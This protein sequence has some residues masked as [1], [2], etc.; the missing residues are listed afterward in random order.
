MRSSRPEFF[1]KDFR[2]LE[3]KYKTAGRKRACGYLNRESKVNKPIQMEAG[4]V[5]GLKQLCFSC[6]RTS[7]Q[8]NFAECITANGELQDI[9]WYNPGS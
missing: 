2:S 4:L 3:V 5:I 7:F 9:F 1:E 6:K 8:Q